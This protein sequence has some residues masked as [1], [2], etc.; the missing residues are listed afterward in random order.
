MSEQLQID[1][2]PCAFRHKGNECSIAAHDSVVSKKQ[3]MWRRIV[4]FV[5]SC[6]KRGATCYEIEV[7]LGLK[8]Q[9]CS[10]RCAELKHQKRLLLSGTKR[11]TDTGRLAGV[12][13]APDFAEEFI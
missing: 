5:A 12:L 10:A 6:G 11:P 9:G 13:I 4:E 1:F 7:A 2:D 3:Q 8:H